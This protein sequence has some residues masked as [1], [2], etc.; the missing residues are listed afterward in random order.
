MDP[1]W[2]LLGV[3]GWA[4]GLVFV[5]VLLSGISDA[6]RERK[7]RDVFSHGRCS[8]AART[9]LNEPPDAER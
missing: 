1:I 3:V 5:L 4:F 8:D 7:R 2:I 9:R 6:R